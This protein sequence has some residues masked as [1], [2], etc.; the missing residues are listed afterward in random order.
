MSSACL[1]VEVNSFMVNVQRRDHVQCMFQGRRSEQSHGKCEET[2][3]CP[4]Y[5]SGSKK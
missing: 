4:V 5:V 2:G 3:P 1:R